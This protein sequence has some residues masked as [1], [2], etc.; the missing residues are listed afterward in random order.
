MCFCI[1]NI[2][3]RVLYPFVV[4]D[5]TPKCKEEVKERGMVQEAAGTPV[6]SGLHVLALSCF[7]ECFFRA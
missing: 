5:G 6:V 2:L 1:V 3:I 4:F 7:A